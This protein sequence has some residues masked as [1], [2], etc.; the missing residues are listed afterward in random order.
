MIFDIILGLS[1]FLISLL[2]T[3]LTILALRKRTVLMDVPNLR[4]NHK[5]PTPRGGGI[6]VVMAIVIGLLLADI[7]YSIVL[8]IFLLAAVSLLDDLISVPPWVRL[9]VQ[10]MAVGLPLSLRHA[11]IFSDA[12]PLWLDRGMAALLWIWFINLFNFMDGIDGISASEM[13][14]IGMGF[15]L[16]AVFSDAFSH[17]LFSYSLIVATAGF[18]FLWWNWHPA[19]IFLGDVG[20]VPIGFI[21]GYLLLMASTSGYLFPA[22]ILPAYYLADG[23]LTLLRRLCERKKIWVAHSEHYYQ[24][25]VRA[26]RRHDRVTLYIFGVNLLLI[27]LAVFSALHPHIAV[28]CLAM[29]YLAVFMLLGFFAHDRTGLSHDSAA[30]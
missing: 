30:L 25:A 21:I 20:S 1:V 13:I 15:C 7:H 3:R 26:G 18:G 10:A 12:L 11:P 17:N 27:L 28:I 22:L 2:G 24:R 5:A 14:C 4:S 19:R 29:A 9:L 23:T 16:L 6:A 8:A